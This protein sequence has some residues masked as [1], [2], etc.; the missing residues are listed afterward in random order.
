[1]TNMEVYEMLINT[2]WTVYVSPEMMVIVQEA[3][4]KARMLATQGQ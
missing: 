3:I 2:N 4:D 1:M